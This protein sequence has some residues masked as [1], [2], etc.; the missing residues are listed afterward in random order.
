MIVIYTTDRYNPPCE[1]LRVNG[2]DIIIHFAP[3][4]TNWKNFTEY[5]KCRNSCGWKLS[6]LE[7]LKGILIYSPDDS[8]S[9]VISDETLQGR[10]Q[11]TWTREP[12]NQYDESICIDYYDPR[13]IK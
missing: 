1:N 8:A 2:V 5:K 6:L 9:S 11:L 4:F 3:Y 7:E 12:V 10:L 13:E